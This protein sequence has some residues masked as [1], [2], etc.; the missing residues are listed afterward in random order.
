MIGDVNLF[1]NDPDDELAAEIDVMIAESS[2]RGKV[3]SETDRYTV[4]SGTWFVVYVSGGLYSRYT[5]DQ[6]LSLCHV[7]FKEVCHSIIFFFWFWSTT[8]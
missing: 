7:Y 3:R 1:L 8:G 2:A 5:S 4:T 6:W